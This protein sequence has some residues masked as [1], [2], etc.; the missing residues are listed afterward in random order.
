MKTDKTGGFLS[1]YLYKSTKAAYVCTASPY[2][3]NN[4]ICY[5]EI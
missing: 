1:E 5:R 3:S 4:G 2:D